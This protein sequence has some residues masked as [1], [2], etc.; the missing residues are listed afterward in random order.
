MAYQPGINL[1]EDE[2][3]DLLVGSC[4]ILNTCKNQ[5]CQFLNVCEVNDI[6]QLIF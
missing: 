3:E 2:K 5:L 4:G 1:V 6:R